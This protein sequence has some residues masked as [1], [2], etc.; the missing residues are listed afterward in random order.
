MAR[1]HDIKA[2]DGFLLGGLRKVRSD[3]TILFQRGYWQA[4]KD[5]AGQDVWVHEGADM[6]GKGTLHAAPP[7]M[8]IYRARMDRIHVVCERTEKRD[9][10]PG[11]RNAVN[12]AWAARNAAARE[13]HP[14][15]ERCE[16][17][18]FEVQLSEMSRNN[19]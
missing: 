7:G 8:H 13:D 17:A 11:Y 5:W 12:E 2:P 10:K 1:D 6:F 16:R 9:A 3:G 15:A 18:L 14:S 4:P 19:R